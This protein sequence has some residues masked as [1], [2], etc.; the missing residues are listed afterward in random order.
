MNSGVRIILYPIVTYII[1][2]FMTPFHGQEVDPWCVRGPCF[3]SFSGDTLNEMIIHI[4]SSFVGYFIVWVSCTMTLSQLSVGLPLLLSTPVAVA[5]YY[6]D[7]HHHFNDHLFPLFR[8]DED[9]FEPFVYS[10][11][12]ASFLWVSE[13]LAMGFYICTKTNIILAT[14][15]DM[16]LAPHY[17]SL[18]LEQHTILNRQVNKGAKRKMDGDSITTVKRRNPRMIFICSTMYRETDT[19]MKQMLASILRVSRHYEKQHRKDPSCCDKYE[20]HIFFDGAISANQIENFGLQLLSLLEDTLDIKLQKGLKKRTPYGYRF[21]WDLGVTVRMPF[22]IHFK[23]K[24]LVK[25]KKRWSQVMYMN[26]VINHRIV[27]ENLSPHDTFILTTDADIDFTANSVVVLLDM[28]APN[29]NVAAVCARTHPKGHGLL[30]W[31]QLFDYAIGHWFQKPAEHILGSVLCSPGCFS[32]FRCSALKLVLETYSTEVTSA[33]EFLMKDMGEDRWL[34]T[35]LVKEGL[36]LEYCAISEDHTYCPTEFD[37]FYKQRRRWIPSTVAN[38]VMLVSES[39]II[40]KGNDSISILYILFQ[41]I[42]IFSTA[43]SPATVILVIAAVLQTFQI[44]FGF[45]VTFLFLLS[46]GYGLVCL[47]ASPK[48]QLDIAK[49]LTFIFALIMSVVIVGLFKDLIDALLGDPNK[50]LIGPPNCDNFIEGGNKTAK[51]FDCMKGQAFAANYT[52]GLYHTFQMPLPISVVYLFS[53][54]ATFTIAG[55]FHLPELHCLLH[56][57]WFLLGMPSGNAS[58]IMLNNLK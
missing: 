57:L 44:P 32:V 40:T 37:E 18:F 39:G 9:V 1:F 29:L 14:D 56:S 52:N 48:T 12:V 35:L 53:L 17:D 54:A 20:S 31:Y 50:L 42:M 10:S 27:E 8:G 30:Y 4:V 55:L 34:C 36:R 46:I 43:I 58:L 21:S 7:V 51:Y 47:Y 24:T 26:Y 15:N 23:D 11:I 38:L 25:A 22:T 33:L 41:V 13:V 19:E 45:T 6:L 16:F 5:I 2:R 3:Q 49:F 28:L